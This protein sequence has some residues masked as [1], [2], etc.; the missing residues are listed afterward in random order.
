MFSL[1][2]ADIRFAPA[3][4]DTGM[5]IFSGL[6]SSVD[7]VI[8]STILS[9]LGFFFLILVGNPVLFGRLFLFLHRVDRL[10]PE[11]SLHFVLFRRPEPISSPSLFTFGF[12]ETSKNTLVLCTLFVT[13]SSFSIRV[14]LTFSSFSTRVGLA[15]SSF[16]TRVGL[17]F[18]SFSTRVGLTFSSLNEAWASFLSLGENTFFPF[19]DSVLF[20]LLEISL[21]FSSLEG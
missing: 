10:S 19:A 13:V 18:S 2:S 5:T 3:S 7:C 4:G 14:G 21:E 9:N 16:S 15:F 12:R 11:L 20:S 6:E 17:T 8:I 1:L